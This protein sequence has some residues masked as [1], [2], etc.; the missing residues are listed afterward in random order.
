MR[1][2]EAVLDNLEN[3]HKYVF[4]QHEEPDKKNMERERENLR[5]DDG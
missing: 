4:S 5:C 1:F 2:S 3:L